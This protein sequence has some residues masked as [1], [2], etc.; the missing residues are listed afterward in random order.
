MEMREAMIGISKGRLAGSDLLDAQV[1][2]INSRTP[3]KFC[4]RDRRGG[5]LDPY[6][7]IL[8]LG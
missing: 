5:L 7:S 1:D 2:D 3:S 8:Y 6:V 4:S